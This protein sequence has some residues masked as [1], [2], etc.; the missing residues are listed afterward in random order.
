MIAGRR[1]SSGVFRILAVLLL[2]IGCREIEPPGAEGGEPQPSGV[3]LADPLVPQ[4][5]KA[6]SPPVD[7]AITETSADTKSYSYQLG[8]IRIVGGEQKS[9]REVVSRREPLIVNCVRNVSPAEGGLR[10][11][12]R[13]NRNGTVDAAR[14]LVSAAVSDQNTGCLKHATRDMQFHPSAELSVVE[15]VL[16]E[17][18]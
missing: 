13:V 14:M 17:K 1:G 7:S 15:L 11:V 18:T 3:I 8:E 10:I 12:L 9:A 4:Q 5:P 16:R 2:V 6:L